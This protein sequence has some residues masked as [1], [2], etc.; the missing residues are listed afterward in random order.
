MAQREPF[1][2]SNRAPS[3]EG[4][5]NDAIDLGSSEA[6]AEG[7]SRRLDTDTIGWLTTIRRDGRPHAVPV[8]FLW[9]AGAVLIMS[10]PD[11]VKVKNIRRNPHALIH[12]HADPSGN[13]VVVLDGR[14]TISDRTSIQ[15]LAEIRESYA[16]KY[17]DAMVAFGMGLDDIAATFSTVIVLTPQSLTA[18]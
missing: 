10:E 8:W 7:V 9:H 17:A 6:P 18:W 11:T 2:P 4:I 3:V 13:G 15:W 16:A 14:A 5:S 1:P 12:L